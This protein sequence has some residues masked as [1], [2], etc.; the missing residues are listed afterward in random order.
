MSF[1]RIVNLALRAYPRELRESRGA[2]MR[3]TA[4]EA[5]GISRVKLLRESLGLA[6]AGMSARARAAASLV[7]GTSTLSL[8]AVAYRVA[9]TYAG[10]W[11]SLL[12]ASTLLVLTYIV[13]GWSVQHTA[14]PTVTPPLS[15][16]VAIV[17]LVVRV[18][19]LASFAAFA[20]SRGVSIERKGGGVRAALSTA[21][22]AAGDMAWILFVGSIA[23][24][25]AANLAKL[26]LLTMLVAVFGVSLNIGGVTGG[27]IAGAGVVGAL[28]FVGLLTIW[29]V[30]L[31]VAMIEHPGG[32]SALARSRELMRGNGLRALVVVTIVCV[33]AEAARLLGGLLTGA[34]GE[35]GTALAWLPVAPIPLL[36]ATALYLELGE[37]A[38][39]PGH[40][41]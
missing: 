25:T 36:A 40:T 18:V 39:L 7:P 29:S 24:A 32:M 2:E 22:S 20:I 34:A 31:P 30:A 15:G 6:G 33:V 5:S 35:F 4:L 27:G 12:S 11:R 13:C 3:D 21:R 17:A 37:A 26:A 10:A 16:I 38:P 8:H 9:R 14:V 19:A 41:A 1:E 23:L 28:P